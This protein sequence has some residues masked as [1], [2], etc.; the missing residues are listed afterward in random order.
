MPKHEYK[1]TFAASPDIHNSMK[2]KAVAFSL[3]NTAPAVQQDRSKYW[4]LRLVWVLYCLL[5]V[6]PITC[7]QS[8]QIFHKAV[9]F[10]GSPRLE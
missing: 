6:A 3:F 9:A 8:L 2:V 7:Q 1:D 10:T 5:S 4:A